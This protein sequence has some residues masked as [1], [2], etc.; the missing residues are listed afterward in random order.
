MREGGNCV[1]RPTYHCAESRALLLGAG[2][3]YVLKQRGEATAGETLGRTYPEYQIEE[4]HRV[5]EAAHTHTHTHT[6][7]YYS[8]IKRNEFESVVVR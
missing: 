6:L 2:R 7:E 1:S 3:G 5:L 8:A 4:E